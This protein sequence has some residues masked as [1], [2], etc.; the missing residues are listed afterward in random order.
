MKK[1]VI[2]IPTYNEAGNIEK[3]VE[4]IFSEAKKIA[5][6]EL[7]VLIV[8]S[9]SQDNTDT[10]VKGLQKKHP[11]LHLLETKKEGLGKAYINGF[12]YA[13][14]KLNPYVICE[15]DAD[16]SHDPKKIPE[17]LRAI[18]TG[19]DFALGSR[20]IT[21][22]SIPK[23]WGI[24]RK[25]FSI[26]G[27]L[28]IRFGFFNLKIT[29]WT[30][31]FRAIKSW[32]VK[33]S[34]TYINRYTGYVFQVALLDNAIKRHAIVKEVPIHFKDR[35]IGISKI[36]FAQYMSHTLF[37]VFT[38][39]SFVKFV[40]VGATGF[41]LDF[42]ISYILIEKLHRALWL[43]TLI[44]TESAIVNNFLLNNSWSFAHKKI[45]GGK[46]SYLSSFF[47][48][49][50]VSSGSIVIQTIG[51]LILDKIFG[52]QWWYIYKIVLIV[53]IIIPYSFFFYNRFV[54]K[55]K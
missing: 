1:A 9:T 3:V 16:L 11:R 38:H 41:I 30:G 24:H 51:I 46:R 14:E 47:K 48:F 54:W 12:Q 15:M 23:E 32:I 20:Y 34:L 29:D 33:D 4:Q 7:Y 27:N 6:W 40:I 43:S 53:C 18:E 35:T 5:N 8:D 44:S 13:L 52:S 26:F 21:G 45:E 49:N 25:F 17:L 36:N 10:I 37:Y 55:N 42:S 19:A 2:V 31:G 22:G 50:L 28:V 39:S